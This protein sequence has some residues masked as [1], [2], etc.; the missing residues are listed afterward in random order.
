M[1]FTDQPPKR[2]FVTMIAELPSDDKGNAGISVDSRKHHRVDGIEPDPIEIDDD[3]IEVEDDEE[4]DDDVVVIASSPASTNQLPPANDFAALSKRLMKDVP[5]YP[6]S[7]EAHNVWEIKDWS[8]L[9]EEKVRGPTFKCGNFEWNVLLFPRGNNNNVSIYM[10]PHPL[11]NPETGEVD[12]DW[13]VCALFALDV[14]N[15]DHPESHSANGSS[16][17]F[18]KNE[19]D[20]GFSSLIDL[21]Q[22]STIYKPGQTHPIMQ[23]NKLN[24]TG[25]VKIVDDS[26]TGVLWHSFMDYD[27]KKNAGYVGLNNQGATCYLNS[28]L[29]SY[30]TTKLF[31]KLVYQI[32]TEETSA[33]HSRSVPLALQR[34]FYSLLTS[35]DT[36]ST[37]EL[38]K[39]FGW[40][41]SDA[42]TQHDVQELNRILMDK[43]E[44]AMK[45]TKIENAL[46]D[47]FVGKMK[48]YIKCVNV[49]Y[50]S[51]RVED[52]WDIQL[53]V[54]G[55]KN[56]QESFKNY[57]EIEMLDGENKYQA[58]DEHGY[59]DAKKGVVFR[60]FPPVLH[61]QLKRFEYDFMVDDLVKIDDLYEF[62]EKIDLLPYL[63]EDLSEQEK[64]QN[65]NYKLHGVL[66]HQGSISNGH[67]YA[68]I[69]PTADDNTWLRFDDDKVWKVTPT[70]VFQENFGANELSQ[71][72]LSKSTRAE[73]SEYLVR[74]A[75]S[76]YM[77]VYYREADLESVLPN[78]D[79]SIDAAIPAHIPKQMQEEK[80]Q[81][82]K[83][84]K[85]KEEALYYVNVK[86]VTTSNFNNYNGFDTYPDPTIAKFYEDSIIDPKSLPVSF[87][88]KKEDKISSLYK[89]VDHHLRGNDP[90]DVI[91]VD[92][93]TQET[94]DLSKYPFR[95]V[96]VNHRNNHT[97]RTD[98]PIPS[99]Y[100]DWTVNQ[101]YA[102]CFNR[103]YDEMV[104]YVEEINKD[105][106]EVDAVAKG[107]SEEVSPETFDIKKVFDKINKTPLPSEPY[108][109]K[110]IFDNSS[111]YQIFI[112]Y[113]DPVI[114]EVRGL[115]HVN[116]YKGDLVSSLT[117]PI[118]KLLGFAESTP[119]EFFEELSQVKTENVDINLTFEKN[120]LSNGDIL[121]VQV[122]NVEAATVGKKFSN[123][124]D[125][126]RFL[127]TKLHIRVKP[128][129]AEEDEED[130]DFVAEDS[131]KKES[132]DSIG[133][134]KESTEAKEIEMAKEISKSFDVWISTQYS[135]DDLANEIVRKLGTNVDANYLRIF[136]VNNQG[137]RYPLKS[138]QLLSQLFPKT[139]SASTVTNFEYEILNITLR[140][141]ENMK[142]IKIFWL[143]SVLQYQLFDLLVPKTSTVRDLVNKLIHKLEISPKHLNGLLLW[144]G[145]KHKYADLIKFDRS[146]ESINE[147]Y[148]LY[149]GYFP[150]EV[151][152]LVDHDMIKRFN[153]DP[154]S[155]D[156]IDDEFLKK[157]FVD[158]KKYAKSLNI[159]PAFHFYKNSTNHHGIPFIFP[160]YPGEAY[161][162]TRE[163]LRL[164]L[165]LGIQAFEKIKLALADANDKGRYIEPDNLEL[166]LFE[167]VAKFDSSVSLAL[168]HPDRTPRRQNPF[169]KGISI[170]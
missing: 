76:A 120:E 32:P 70:Q 121:A 63:D 59:Q 71:E 146:I 34:V 5:D 91:E 31:R 65:W 111:H 41:S 167:E 19:T 27:S 67:Y 26:S 141:Y 150:A 43:L 136:V 75:T 20:W 84:E 42:F 157:D 143:N 47:I 148:E 122:A 44:T 2:P 82:E 152:I 109:F 64:N 125:Y 139:V 104:F 57:I 165:G 147:N 166:N 38:T 96:L 83:L 3:D 99:E 72:V 108:K 51:S 10:E 81:T 98:T 170:K 87:K 106:Q 79:S 128:F 6:I 105:L 145:L 130:S 61:L 29:Q 163:R 127:L 155:S 60:S 12:D 23:G 85:L 107:T 49:A 159:V 53:N 129:K 50:E 117:K 153:D 37:L 25:Y 21:K 114:N 74:R 7:D 144:A 8:G 133:L 168:D 69:K 80:E 110:D 156:N 164:K 55:F 52:F 58:G 103:K 45:G 123:V 112:K 97:N 131:D 119:L 4:D 1:T 154:V 160:V 73:Q 54:K 28:L 161:S 140:E 169:D 62:P 89:L 118:N 126:Y 46:N 92:E 77:L 116:V 40:D 15:P 93:D 13:Y 9:K 132:T 48:S 90:E 68:M 36:I 30:F 56:L 124:K 162:E 151:E 100:E 95:L 78:D 135:Y 138:T 94:A 158:A 86:F 18:N 35:D 66:V 14:W 113:F 102:K 17:R 101:V 149:I 22:L 39:S 11:P 134:D 16:H 88:V 115:T 142:S 33:S 137:V 24:I